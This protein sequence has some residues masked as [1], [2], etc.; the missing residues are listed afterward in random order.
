M[1][2]PRHIL[3]VCC[4]VRNAAND[5]LLVHHKE[6]GWELPQGG[7]EEGEDIVSAIHREVIEES[8]VTIKSARL[9]VIW[10][11]VSDPS[12]IIHGFIADYSAGDLKPSD[13]T[14]EVAWFDEEQARTMIEHPVNHDRLCDLIGFSGVVDFYCYATGPYR[15][16]PNI[17]E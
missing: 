7:V 14:P 12:A 5:I 4:L 6:R 13:E 11:K 1:I 10:S 15:R 3:V 16:I 2:H 9:A 8:G 17:V